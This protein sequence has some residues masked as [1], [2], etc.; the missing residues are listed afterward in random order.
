MASAG[1]RPIKIGLII[2]TVEDRD[3]ETTPRW[4]DVLARARAAEAAGFSSIW[5]SDHLIHRVPDFPDYGIWECWSIVSALAAVTERVEIGNWVLGGGF[6]NPGLLAKMADTVDEISN[7]RLILGIGAGWH[8]PEYLAFGYP[9]D[10]RVGRFEEAIAIVHGLLRDGHVDYEGRFY[11]ARDSELRP[12]GPRATGAK[13]M[14]GTI[15]GTPLAGRFGVP[16]TSPKMVRFAARYAE[17]WN[18]PWIND[19]AIAPPIHQSVDAVCREIG[20]DPETLEHSHGLMLD[21]PGW[22]SEPG[23]TMMR[24]G[25][26]AMG[27]VEGTAAQHVELIRR[28][29]AAGT[30]EV[31]IQLDPETPESIAEFAGVIETVTHG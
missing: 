7:G 4:S 8:E 23:S 14:I 12:R 29:A 9:F 28:F 17:I 16:G 25:R 24:A 20:R 21:L 26:K 30:D 19:P 18:C 15:G 11:R 3:G 27:S 31:H 6:R 2:S 22:Q 10:H 1:E 13:I 5:I